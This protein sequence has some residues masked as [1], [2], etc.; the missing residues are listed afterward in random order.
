MCYQLSVDLSVQCVL[1]PYCKFACAS[2]SL[3]TL[4]LY[5][6]SEDLLSVVTAAQEAKKRAARE[7]AKEEMVLALVLEEERD[8]KQKQQAEKLERERYTE[9]L[10][11][12]AILSD[13]N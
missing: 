8:S 2:V 6:N 9:S 4:I 11:L 13:R 10:S 5:S 3:S 12:F 1:L 7:Q